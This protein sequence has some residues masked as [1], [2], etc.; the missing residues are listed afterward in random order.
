[1][2]FK[3]NENKYIMPKKEQNKLEDMF[4]ELEPR[5][6]KDCLLGSKRETKDLEIQNLEE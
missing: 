6:R 3:H 5:K 4:H 1:M 2:R